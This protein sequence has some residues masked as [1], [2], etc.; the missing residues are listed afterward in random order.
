[1]KAFNL[2]FAV[3]FIAFAALQYNDPDPY[4]WMPIYLYSAA[5][6]YMAFKGRFYP[7]AYLF[8]IAI[9]SAY[10]AYLFF[11]KTGVL[12]WLTQHH[13]ESM[14]Q[15]MQAQKPWIEESR[16]FFG[17]VILIAVLTINHVYDSRRV[18]NSRQL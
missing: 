16:E 9:Y 6:C 8:G 13:A 14:V 7:K 17:L 12:S 1:M 4:I 18:K 10:A 15:T 5:L 11:D 2:I 3:L